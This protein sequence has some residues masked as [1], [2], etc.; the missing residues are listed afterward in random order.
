MTSQF[1]D[2]NHKYSSSDLVTMS[3][4]YIILPCFNE[5]QN[6]RCLFS[7]LAHQIKTR[8]LIVVG[9]DDGSTDDT[10]DVLHYLEKEYP[11]KIIQHPNNMGLSAALRSG[12]SLAVSSADEKDV[13]AIMDGDN[14]HDPEYLGKM[15]YEIDKGADVVIASRY[16]KGGAQLFVPWHR[17]I[18]SRAVNLIIRLVSGLKIRDA[19]SGYRCFKASVLKDVER[20]FGQVPRESKGFEGPLEVLSRAKLCT[21]KIV[22]IPFCL[23]Y[24]NKKGKSKM[25]IPFTAVSYVRLL[26][27]VALWRL[28]A[29]TSQIS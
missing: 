9:V 6:L 7:R 19:T 26:F 16:V 21:Q 10:V 5:S 14:T 3:Q 20:R 29:R 22:E 28:N 4:L 13:I 11:V 1:S 15:L 24:N 2:T 8:K 25:N 23:K 27:K 17:K 18:L 12:L